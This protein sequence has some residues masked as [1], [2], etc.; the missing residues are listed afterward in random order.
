MTAPKGIKDQIIEMLNSGIP[1]SKIVLTLN[2][3]KA[4]IWYHA[5]TLGKTKR[6]EPMNKQLHKYNWVD[7]KSDLQHGITPY[8]CMIKY[9][10]T[11][12]TWYKAINKIKL[13]SKNSI[14]NTN[15]N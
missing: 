6:I 3:S 13:H 11:R 2:C 15:I 1:Y 7:I 5:N 12:D 4:T 10:F 8:E 14:I 9:N